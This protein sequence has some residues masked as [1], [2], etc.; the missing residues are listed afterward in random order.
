M[1]LL[2]QF[3]CKKSEPG[4]IKDYSVDQFA[5]VEILRYEVPGFE[6]L[7]LQQKT[8][9]YYLNEAALQG[10]DILFDQN[11]RH[12]LL[13]RKVL[14]TIYIHA[15]VQRT[16]SDWK[17][18]ETYLKRVWVSNGIHHHYSTDKFI[19]GFSR[20]F[21]LEA[22]GNI[23][24][25]SLPLQTGETVG[26]LAEK[27]LP[28]LFDPNVDAK[29][30]NQKEGEDLIAT[31]ANNYYQGVTQS[32][33][34]AFYDALKNP[35]DPQ[36]VS[37]GLNSRL[38]KEDGRIVEKVW[39]ADGLYGSAIQA[40]LFWLDKAE[41]VAE[42][43]QQTQVIH[44]LMDYYRTGDLKTFDD[45]CISWTQD[46][47]SLVDFV[48]GFTET[49]GDPM[50]MKASWE[51][52]VNF[53]NVEA[54]KRTEIIS[55]NAQWFEDHS[56]ID[57]TF[58]KETVK[59]VTAKV[60]TATILGGDCYPTTPIG[61]NLPN[62]NWIRRDYGS[63]SVTIENIT[64][65]YD[66]AAQ[67]SGFSE[68]FIWD[69]AER[70]RIQTY[71]FLTDNLHTDL[72]ECLGHGSGKLLP[73]VDPDALKAYGA[74]I[75]E[76][77]ADLF[78]LYYLADP[79]MVELG[80]V[81]DMEAYKAQYY[82]YLMNGLLTQ[83]TRIE[84]GNLIEQAHMRNRALITRWVL[85]KGKADNIVELR[86]RDDKTYVVVN[87]YEKLRNLFAQLLVEI[88]RIKSTGDFD[89]AKKLIESY[90]IQIDPVLHKEILDR[91]NALNLAPYKGFVNPVYTPVL[92]ADGNIV[93][94]H[95][96][97]D[98]DYTQ[99]HLRYSRDYSTLPIW[100]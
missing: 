29:R 38:V 42:N 94:V 62:S 5:D 54:T 47:A 59:G 100:N 91:Y 84:P 86:K 3:S 7:S 33:V 31:S 45:Y 88:Q 12:N 82:K 6:S 23:P 17:A 71:G 25:D 95:I 46:T 24:A 70:K 27:L 98:E 30:V 50:G 76:T 89:A 16:T 34:E 44:Q 56:P 67:G 28:I 97:Y 80:L 1:G 58:K 79:I 14:E 60:I 65:A 53:K 49:Y 8:L 78:G 51:S 96:R 48:N 69:D 35:N 63:K 22:L 90:A 37:H 11:Y 61:I 2:V 26:M 9:I 10:R 18:F 21:F 93:D 77:R 15:D 36:P 73:G 40:I 68:E 64:E 41:K 72:H 39:K 83:L 19:P 74:P 81:P 20:D 85:A 99:Q 32:E 66:A 92:D 57:P 75:E 55:S 4:E 52:I 13:I 43:P 87:D